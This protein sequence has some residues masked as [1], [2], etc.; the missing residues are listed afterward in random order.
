MRPVLQPGIR[1]E[2]RF[3]VP[4]SRTVPALYPESEEFRAMPAVFATGYLVGLLE[5]ACMQAIRPCLD[6]ATQ[7]TLGTH[8]DV[9]HRAA[10]PPGLTV[11]VNVELLEVRERRLRFA[12]AAHDGLDLISSGHHERTL[13]ERCSFDER[14]ARKRARVGGSTAAGPDQRPMFSGAMDM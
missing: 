4:E 11:T 10:T 2:M 12:V 7:L 5:W 6:E 3:T 14:V 13:V 8:I 9:S 1:H